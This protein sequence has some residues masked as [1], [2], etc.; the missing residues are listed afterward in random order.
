MN[1]SVRRSRF[2]VG[3]LEEGEPR[4]VYRRLTFVSVGWGSALADSTPSVGDAL[5]AGFMA[6]RPVKALMSE[7][8][9][10]CKPHAF[11]RSQED[12]AR[13]AVARKWVACAEAF[14]GECSVFLSRRVAIVY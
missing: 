11:L 13:R 7:T 4:P 9:A 8:A 5:H 3:S 12:V 10:V 6:A 14:R 2:Q 1:R